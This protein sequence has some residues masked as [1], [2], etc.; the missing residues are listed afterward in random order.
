MKSGIAPATA[1]GGAG[2]WRMA[3][4]AGRVLGSTEFAGQQICQD[5][6]AAVIR[7]LFQQFLKPGGVLVDDP[8]RQ[9]VFLGLVIHVSL[10]YPKWK[11]RGLLCGLFCP[12]LRIDPQIVVNGASLRF[13]HTAAVPD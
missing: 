8:V 5:L 11:Q 9:N 2:K 6:V 1:A 13:P 4:S 3:L 10:H 7:L 12:S